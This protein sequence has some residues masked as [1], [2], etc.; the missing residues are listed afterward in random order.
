M[1]SLACQPFVTLDEVLGS[2]CACAYTELEDGALIEELIDDATDLLYVLSGGR[3]HGICTRTVWP[4]TDGICGISGVE[5]EV[6]QDWLRANTIPLRGPHTDIVEVTIDGVALSP[7]EYG[8]ANDSY[9]FRR[10]GT[11]PTSN[12]VLLAAT[13]DGTFTITF[14]FGEAPSR[15]SKLATIELVCQMMREPAALSRLRGVVSANVQGVSVTM[16]DALEEASTLGL[17]A[18]TR[19]LDRYSPRGMGALGVYSPELQHGWR[20]LEIEGPSGS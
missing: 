12:N 13:E 6:Y 2:A 15:I 1:P 17:P 16:A 14:R 19:F 4:V 7:S 18:L 9:L 3:V 20:L 10:V 5:V 11:W 8:L